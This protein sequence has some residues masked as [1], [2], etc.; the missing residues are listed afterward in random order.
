M[1]INVRLMSSPPLNGQIVRV[2][3]TDGQNRLGQYEA[4]HN[5]FFMKDCTHP[6]QNAYCSV[7]NVVAWWENNGSL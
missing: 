5:C 4:Y 1:D 3:L 2:L 7:S 6:A